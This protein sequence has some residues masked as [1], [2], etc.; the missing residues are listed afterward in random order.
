MTRIIVVSDTHLIDPSDLPQRL[1]TEAQNA[2]MLIHCGDIVSPEVI[3][4]L[5]QLC[6]VEYVSGNC[7]TYSFD[8]KNTK[9]ILNI[10]GKKIGVIHGW[11]KTVNI[12]EL[13]EQFLPEK[14]DILLFGHTHIKTAEVVNGVFVLNP[15]SP[16]K[17]LD[18][19][20]SFALLDITDGKVSSR[21]VLL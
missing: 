17:P 10:D 16:E 3:E 14:L 4:E 21:F 7:D 13:L 15:G 6:N 5:E 1:L 18:D 12:E 2:D 20:A 11:G 9:L 19:S 8:E